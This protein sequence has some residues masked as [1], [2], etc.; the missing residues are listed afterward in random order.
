MKI[1]KSEFVHSV[2]VLMSGTV[3]AQALTYLI[4]PILT[5]IYSTEEMGD[6][7]IFLRAVGF[8][9][10]LATARYELSIP[11]PKNES[12]SFLLYRLSLQIA[13]YTLIACTIIG[14]VY[15][16]SQPFDV[17]QLVFV[18]ITLVSSIF[19]VIINLGTNWAIRKKHFK[20]ISYSKVTNSFVSNG[21]RW[22]FG[23]MNLGSFG[24]LF[25]SLIGYIVSSFTFFKE[26]FQLK[27]EH[28]GLISAKKTYVLSKVYNQFPMVSL[29]HVLLDLGR[30]LLI[31][32]L[33]ISFFSKDIFGSYNHSYTIL[34]LP[35]A[36]IG[37]SIGQVFFN[38]CNEMINEGK[39]I[40]S[41][42]NKTILSLVA[43]SI[44]P[45][46]VIFFFGKPLF[47][48]VFSEQWEMSG[49]YSEIMAVWL[50]FNFLSSPTSSIPLILHRQ[51]EYFIMGLISTVLQ[52]I[53]FGV[54]PFVLGTS[55][56][57]FVQILWFVSITQ[58]MLLIFMIF[59]TLY[60]ARKG[61]KV[62]GS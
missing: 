20:K 15:L 13:K 19:L 41:L 36:V 43:M 49:Y 17:N 30:D 53:G 59:I 23:V 55:K 28:A 46:T 54:L 7:G 44:I 62:I 27:K 9:S 33:I 51:K 42:L 31:A 11:L 1:K 16:I 60:Y 24:L 39:P 35:L 45:F 38:R 58:T 52:L 3:L 61:V 21:L 4:S 5:R 6:L 2:I 25:A 37:V 47:S 26:L 10:A 29:P 32:S 14:I 57:A 48:F 18:A 56:D 40:I 12:H 50:F 22:F 8:I 34:K